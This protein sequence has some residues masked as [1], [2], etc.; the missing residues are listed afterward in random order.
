[1]KKLLLLL[2]AASMVLSAFAQ[3]LVIKGSDTLGAKLV[4]LLAEDYRAQHPDV[5]FEGYR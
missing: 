5:S 4:P 1:M 2:A 3:Q